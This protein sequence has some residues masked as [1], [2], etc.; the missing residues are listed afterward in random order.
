MKIIPTLLGSLFAFLI[1]TS[2]CWLP[3]LVLLLGGSVLGASAFTAKLDAFS[4]PL[5]LAGMGL[6]AYAGFSFWKKNG[7]KEQPAVV[8]LQA[9]ITC[10]KCGFAK[11]ETMPTNACQFFYE[12]ENCRTV[13]KPLT[14][15]CCVFCSYGT[16]QCPPVQAGDKNCC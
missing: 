12:C 13:L 1:A 4:A 3:G 7:Q 14:G 16:V 11:T 8:I 2:C 6:L 5:L 10:P 15:D 9:V